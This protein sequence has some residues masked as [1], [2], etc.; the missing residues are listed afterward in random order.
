MALNA[1]AVAVAVLAHV[2]AASRDVTLDDDMVAVLVR[3][4]WLI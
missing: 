1:A 2:A 3:G 4:G